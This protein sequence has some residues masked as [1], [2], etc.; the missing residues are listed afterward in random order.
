MDEF[1]P[2]RPAAAPDA[3]SQ[4]NGGS[5]LLA[6]IREALV[7]SQQDFTQGS[8]GRAILILAIPMV[9]EM[10]LESVFGIVDVFFVARLGADA[11]AAVGITES[12]LTPIFAVGLGLSMA[13]TALV[14]RRTGEKNPRAASVAASQAVIL[15]V[16]VSLPV[17][18]LGLFSAPLLLSWMGA[19]AEIIETGS[20]YTTL[21]LA[22]NATILL[23]FMIN[24]IF[25]GGGD[26]AVA[27]R[28]LWLSNGLNIVLDPC[29]I[30]G[31]GP[32]P[33]LGV[34]GAAVA[35]NIGRGIGVCYQLG[36]LF[37]GKARV[38]LSLKDVRVV[39][40][41]MWNLI[42][43]AGGGV[44]QFLIA[45]ASWLGLVRIIAVFGGGAL[46]GYTIALRIVIFALLPSW[47]MSNAAATLVGQNLGANRA[48]RAERSVWITALCN[49]VFLGLVALFFIFFAEE[50]IGIFTGDPGVVPFGVACLRYISYGYIF[51]AF[52]MVLVQA[53]N[54]AGD[55][56]TPTLINFFCYWLFQIPLAYFLALQTQLGADGVFIA[57]AISESSI[58]VVSLLVFR[59]GAWKRRKV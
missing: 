8:I 3:E 52:G 14:A 20:G 54:G 37:G 28:A 33:E 17:A 36:V 44:L 19:S 53:F 38:K 25:R 29:L 15:G 32:F 42:R 10:T 41:V 45:T 2:P 43:V 49:A 56:Y 9:L 6:D 39:P 58:A 34:T 4:P 18:V 57:I 40:E 46:A 11:V 23:L 22:G 50:L 27:M 12:L 48:D 31:L 13:A 26:A 1:R 51:Y 21:M 59:R 7:G 35:T 5:G 30:F 24:G 47:G 55:T 16:L